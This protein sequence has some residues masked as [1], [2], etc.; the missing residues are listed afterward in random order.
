[1]IQ[2]G[3]GH[4]SGDHT[5][6]LAAEHRTD[7]IFFVL[8]NY[9]RR[10]VLTY[11]FGT[12]EPIAL[13]ELAEGLAAWEN[14]V[15]RTMTSSIQRK[16]AYVSLRQTHLPKL[17]ELDIVDFDATRGYVTPGPAMADVTPFLRE[18]EPEATQ[19]PLHYLAVAAVLGTL[20]GMV[21]LGVGL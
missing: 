7:E 17:D 9:R 20:L 2:T 11:L 18:T 21:L 4:D 14:G 13:R 19:Y 5:T 1:M 16:R 8:S 15:D 3:E 10:F 6:L 12:E